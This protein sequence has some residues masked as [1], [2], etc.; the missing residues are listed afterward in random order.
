VESG[1]RSPCNR[2]NL[3][4]SESQTFDRFH[5]F[6]R[7]ARI[8][9]RGIVFLLAFTIHEARATRLQCGSD[10]IW[11]MIGGVSD[12]PNPQ[13]ED[14]PLNEGRR[15]FFKLRPR[16]QEGLLQSLLLAVAPYVANEI[17]GACFRHRQPV[18]GGRQPGLFVKAFLLYQL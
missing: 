10:D 6:L 13:N 2:K 7:R 9:K 15:A 8:P 18:S 4:L 1:S 3:Q 5:E 11:K 16:H 12:D 14:V 17:C